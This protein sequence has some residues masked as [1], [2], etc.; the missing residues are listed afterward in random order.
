MAQN[1]SFLYKIFSKNCFLNGNNT[2]PKLFEIKKNWYWKCC[3]RD[4]FGSF[5]PDG[6]A[7]DQLTLPF[8]GQIISKA[9][10]GILNSSKKGTKKF[11]F[12]T[13]RLVFVRFLEEIEDTQKTF[14]NYLTVNKLPCW[15]LLWQICAALTSW[16]GC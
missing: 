8:K 11:V 9:N 7:P 5:T 6:A 13:M 14:Q 10:Y 1:C 3:Q 15:T 12:T 16:V 2:W 4:G